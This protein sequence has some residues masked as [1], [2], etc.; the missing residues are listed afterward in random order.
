MARNRVRL[1]TITMVALSF[2]FL[3]GCMAGGY[4]SSTRNGHEK[5]YRVEK[6]GSKTLVYEVAKDGTVT[7]HDEADPRAQ[8]VQEGQKRAEMSQAADAERIARIEAAPKREPGAPIYVALHETELD[9]KLKESQHSDGAVFAEVQKNFANDKVIR[10]VDGSEMKKSEWGQVAAALGGKSTKANPAADVEVWSKGRL[11][12]KVG[13][14]KQ[15]GKVGSMWVVVFEA[16][17]SSNYTPATRTVTEEGNIFQNQ[18]V[19]RRLA[20]K[21]KHVIKNEI[22]PTLPADRSL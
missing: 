11:E 21:I 13:I 3:Y 22:G 18:E 19:T 8:Q 17:V 14:N 10:L 4:S 15:T 7:I 12:E 9:A 1:G 5:V 16:T 6:D 2:I 20:D